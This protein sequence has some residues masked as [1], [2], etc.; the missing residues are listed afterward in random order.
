MCEITYFEMQA[1]I[2]ILTPGAVCCVVVAKD[3]IWVFRFFFLVNRLLT[4]LPCIYMRITMRIWHASE[5]WPVENN[6]KSKLINY[7]P[8]HKVS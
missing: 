4:C 8:S 2:S 7:E 1:Q 6:F 5:L 3:L